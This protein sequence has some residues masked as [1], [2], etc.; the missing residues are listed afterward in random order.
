MY[1]RLSPGVQD[2][3]EAERGTQVAGIRGDGPQ[4]VGGGLKQDVID[5]AL[6]LE[7]DCRDWLGQGKDDME[8][9]H[10]QEVRLAV[11]KPLRAGERLALRTVPITT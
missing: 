7:G 11:V 9:R 6:V 3:D 5:H 8:V 2:R 4:G 1:Q 10:R